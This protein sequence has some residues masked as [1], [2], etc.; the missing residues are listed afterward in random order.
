MAVREP[1]NEEFAMKTVVLLI[2]L[3]LVSS[4]IVGCSAKHN[5]PGAKNA[6]RDKHDEAGPEPAKNPE[7][8]QA[9]AKKIHG[10]QFVDFEAEGKEKQPEAGG[11]K[12]AQL[13]IRYTA[14][15]NLIADDF[16]SSQKQL[17]GLVDKYE[18][19][20]AKSD[21]KVTPGSPRTGTWI[22]RIPV[23]KFNVFCEEAQQIAELQNF[24]RD[25][26]DLT[27]E[28]ND[29]QVY[30]EGRKAELENLRKI[31]DKTSLTDSMKNF[32]EVRREMQSV[33]DDYNRKMGRLKLLTELTDLTT[34]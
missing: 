17:L 32:L 30:V 12:K 20:F 14:R 31:L 19:F 13:R 7:A 4:A 22:V 34:I 33:E 26:E 24:S 9:D 16:G 2:L 25:S 11:K 15:I 5:T 27:A 29:L 10:E 8:K 6:A 1:P 28:Y 3:M 23:E 21:V 18:G